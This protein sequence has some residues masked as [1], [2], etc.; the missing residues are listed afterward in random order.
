MAKGRKRADKGPRFSVV[1]VEPKFQGNIGAVARAMKN[2]GVEDLVLAKAPP[3]VVEGARGKLE[4]LRTELA[5]VE[6]SLAAL[7]AKP[8]E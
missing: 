6:A 2:F 3:Q 8:G 1:L 4:E 7:A 5:K